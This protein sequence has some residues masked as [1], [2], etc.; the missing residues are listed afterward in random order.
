MPSGTHAREIRLDARSSNSSR[1]PF[2]PLP[3]PSSTAKLRF[4][5]LGAEDTGASRSPKGSRDPYQNTNSSHS[6]TPSPS[7]KKMFA[8]CRCSV[9]TTRLIP[10]SR[11]RG[12]VAATKLHLRPG[13]T[14]WSWLQHLLSAGFLVFRSHGRAII[15]MKSMEWN[16][17]CHVYGN[18]LYMRLSADA[19]DF[20]K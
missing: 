14:A 15:R 18:L 4:P 20:R 5:E 9:Q 10:T 17:L 19:F 13:D 3:P 2:L 11:S 8:R 6:H 12:S 16:A 1:D 7:H